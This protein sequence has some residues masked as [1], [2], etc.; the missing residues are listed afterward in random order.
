M[1]E[2]RPHGRSR[3]KGASAGGFL[4]AGAGSGAARLITG[5]LPP[6][7]TLERH[8]ARFKGTED[9]LV[10]ATGYMANV[11]TISAIVPFSTTMSTAFPSTLKFEK[12]IL[13]LH[14][15]SRWRKYSRSAPFAQ[16]AFFRLKN[17][18]AHCRID[19]LPPSTPSSN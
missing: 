4:S 8:L 16:R 11:G 6:H 19:C 18:V 10:W 13:L 15:L 9:A 1:N 7:L 2:E 14:S 5:T 17:R 3:R 12:R